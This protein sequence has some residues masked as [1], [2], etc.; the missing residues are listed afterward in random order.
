MPAATSR[1][2][3]RRRPVRAVLPWDTG[4]RGDRGDLGLPLPGGGGR[5][6]HVASWGVPEGSRS[7][8]CANPRASARPVWK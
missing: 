1:G 4:M 7:L 3:R 2:A 8:T 6:R 5:H